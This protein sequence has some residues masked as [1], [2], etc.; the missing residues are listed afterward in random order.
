MKELKVKLDESF[1]ITITDQ[2]GVELWKEQ[3][4]YDPATVFIRERS[5]GGELKV[6]TIIPKLKNSTLIYK[7]G[8]SEIELF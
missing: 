7:G 4:S 8:I 6:N 5:C 1:E 3:Y 2:N